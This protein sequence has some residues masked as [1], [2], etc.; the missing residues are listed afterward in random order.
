MFE[1]NHSG[2]LTKDAFD[3][4]PKT[5]YDDYYYKYYRQELKV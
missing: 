3:K 4:L 5:Q 2:I 1:N